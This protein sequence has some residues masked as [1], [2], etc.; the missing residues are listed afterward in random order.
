MLSL[1][2]FAS[3]L[4]SVALVPRVIAVADNRILQISSSTGHTCALKRDGT[5]ACWGRNLAGE[6]GNANF[7]LQT[8]PKLVS[9]GALSG[10]TVTQI[11][12]GGAHTCALLSDGSVACWGW[13]ISGQ[14]GNGNTN[15]SSTPLAVTGGALT[16]KTV[17]QIAAGGNRTCALIDDGSVACWGFLFNNG[18]SEHLPENFQLTPSLIT[19]GALN[20]A[21]VAQIAVAESHFCALLTIGNVACWGDNYFGQIGDGTTSDVELPFLVTSGLLESS[22]VVQIAVTYSHT[23]ALLTDER[24]ACWGGN[25]WGQLGDGSNTNRSTPTE[26][27]GGAINGES[28]TQIAVGNAHSCALLANGALTC[29]GSNLDGEI[30]V[31]GISTTSVPVL[32]GGG[33][34]YGKTVAFVSAAGT[35]TC[36]VLSDES[37]SCWGTNDLG[38]LGDGTTRNQNAPVSVVWPV[39]ARAVTKPVINGQARVGQTLT[40]NKGRWTGA[41]TPTF[42]YKWYACT[43]KVASPTQNVPNSCRAINGASR[44]TLKLTSAQKGKYI[45]VQVTGNSTGTVATRWLSK[46]INAKVS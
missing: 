17:V 30:G 8:V 36:A 44:T 23:C 6:L 26:V 35:I 1:A 29:W 39:R 2:L 31:P 46:T 11:A 25:Y 10:K 22:S 16:G 41:P 43:A 24:M 13:N 18:T 28:I 37:A 7:E 9:G 14:L 12:A 19:S 20:G 45:A 34:L 42:T 15:D 38:Q 5:V 21:T 40:A 4:T 27:S 33:A 3:C 32:V